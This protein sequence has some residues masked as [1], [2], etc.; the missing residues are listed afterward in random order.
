M[1]RNKRHPKNENNLSTAYALARVT[2]TRRVKAKRRQQR[3]RHAGFPSWPGSFPFGRFSYLLTQLT[4]TSRQP[5]KSVQGP[6][7]MR[8]CAMSVTLRPQALS[9][10]DLP[11]FSWSQA[12]MGGDGSNFQGTPP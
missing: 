9:R 5:A 7:G 4:P 6:G 12:R 2:V 11:A 1:L 8:A 3:T 10:V